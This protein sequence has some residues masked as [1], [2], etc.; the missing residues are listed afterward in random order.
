MVELLIQVIMYTG[1]PISCT[2][3]CT[4]CDYITQIKVGLVKHMILHTRVLHTRVP[5]SCTNCDCEGRNKQ[6]NLLET[7]WWLVLVCYIYMLIYI[8]KI[9]TLLKND[10][11]Y[12]MI[13][14]I[15]K[16]LCKQTI[17]YHWVSLQMELCTS[18]DNW[19]SGMVNNSKCM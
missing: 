5:F 11:I 18:W 12:K 4:T 19:G 8:A 2:I 3:S 1:K 9:V 6:T 16:Y 14:A 10:L 13:N 7:I 17:V 15:D